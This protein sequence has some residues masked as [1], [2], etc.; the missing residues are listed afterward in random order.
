MFSFLDHAY[1]A[2][3]AQLAPGRLP[4]RFAIVLLAIALLNAVAQGTEN[5]PEFS[6]S[7]GRRPRRRDRP[8][9][10]MERKPEHQMEDCHP[11]QGL[12]LTCDLGK[13]DL[14]DDRNGRRQTTL[15]ALRG[16]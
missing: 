7:I 12:V 14:A 11:R 16:S 6:R 3:F 15:R 2:S 5:W 4:L 13:P 8:A 9:N 1:R 10:S